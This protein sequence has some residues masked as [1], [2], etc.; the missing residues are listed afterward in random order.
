MIG[1]AALIGPL[2]PR[3]GPQIADLGTV[4][5]DIAASRG[6]GRRALMAQ[7]AAAA[8]GWLALAFVGALVLRLLY[9]LALGC[10]SHSRISLMVVTVRMRQ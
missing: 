5:A 4:V 9:P 8:A 7:P 3:A 6:D 2:P 1:L 10:F